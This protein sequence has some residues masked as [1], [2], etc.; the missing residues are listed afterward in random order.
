VSTRALLQREKGGKRPRPTRFLARV[1]LLFSERLGSLGLGLTVLVAAATLIPSGCLMLPGRHWE[2]ARQTVIDPINSFLHRDLPRN[3]AAKDLDAI[4]RAYSIQTG[5]GISWSG[6]VVEVGDR[7]EQRLQWQGP[8]GEESIRDRYRSLF[9]RFSTIERAELRIHRVHWKEP[10][11]RGYPAEVRFIVRGLAP[12]GHL[13]FLDQRARVWLAQ[14]GNRWLLAGEEIT[15]RELVRT[16]RP[17]FE[18]ATVAAGLQNI[19][20]ATGAARYVGDSYVASGIAVTDFDC[21]GFED[22]ALLS[23]SSITLYRNN[24]DGT[25]GNLLAPTGLPESFDISATGLVFFDADNDGDPDLWLSGVWGDRF[26]RNDDCARFVD[27]TAAAGIPRTRWSS[28]PIVADYDR[29]GFLD[30]Y[31]VRMG[32]HEND[33]PS[34][35]WDARD[36][37]PDSLYRNNGNGTFTDVAAAAGIR[38]TTWGLAGAWGDYNND[39]YPDVYVGNEFGENLLYRNN[40]DGTFTDVTAAA[41]VRDR[42]AAM[43]VAWGDYDNDGDLDL[44]V[45]NMYANSRWVLFHPEFPPPMPWYLIPWYLG[46]TPSARAERIVDELTRGNTLLRNNGDGTFTDVSDRAGIRDAQWGWG[47]AFLDYHNDGWLDVYAANGMVT[48]PL[49]DDV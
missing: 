43:G 35:G 16:R 45:S 20:D 22:L 10:G 3:V 13:Q 31:V 36:G 28:M 7:M 23:A 1:R 44:F 9:A 26:F 30:V 46:W 17:G 48:G 34:P 33:A 19:H 49:P 47:V 18:V 5:N 38:G 27:A 21:D 8:P 42:G 37:L 12:D 2:A 15:A 14:N 40:R 41:G 25:F 32:D 11:G 4:L 29:D 39:G 24:G 6:P